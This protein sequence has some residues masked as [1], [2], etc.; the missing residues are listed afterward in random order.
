MLVLSRRPREVIRI[1]DNIKIKVLEVRGNQVKIGI[2]APLEIEVH[3][4]EIYE[5]LQAEKAVLAPD[6]RFKEA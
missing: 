2:E 4:E 3:R 6:F 5:R 1:G